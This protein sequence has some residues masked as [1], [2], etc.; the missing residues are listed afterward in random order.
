[1]GGLVVIGG[2]GRIAQMLQRWI[3]QVPGSCW[4]AR[5]GLTTGARKQGRFNEK[6][7]S[8]GTDREPF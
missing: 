3:C 2:Q 8:D 7:L 6:N 1:M 5:W 4:D